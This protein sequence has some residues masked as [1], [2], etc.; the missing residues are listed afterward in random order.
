MKL[1]ITKIFYIEIYN[2]E[3]LERAHVRTYVR[4]Y[5]SIVQGGLRVLELLTTLLPTSLG[6]VVYSSKIDLDGCSLYRR[7]FYYLLRK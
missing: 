1:N 7:P 5:S 6:F 3:M 2:G 4:T